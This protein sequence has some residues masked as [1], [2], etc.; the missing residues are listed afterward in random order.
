[1]KK[2]ERLNQLAEKILSVLV[3]EEP[4]EKVVAELY[5][6]NRHAIADE[7]KLLISKVLVKP[8][9]YLEDGSDSGMHYDSDRMDLYSFTLTSKGVEYLEAVS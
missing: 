9:R 2:T 7:I 1:M 8:C 5:P 6:E 4:F 3:Y